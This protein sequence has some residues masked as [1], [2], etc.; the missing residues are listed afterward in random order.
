MKKSMATALAPG[1]HTCIN[2][3]QRI[4]GDDVNGH[5]TNT[6]SASDCQAECAEN[7]D[8]AKFTYYADTKACW[9]QDENAYIDPVAYEGADSG[10]AVCGDAT[11]TA[12]GLV[13]AAKTSNSTAKRTSPASSDDSSIDSSSG[14]LDSL[15][16]SSAGKSSPSSSLPNYAWYLIA[17]AALFLIA[18]GALAAKGGGRKNKSKRARKREEAAADAARAP[19]LAM[20]PDVAVS[21][22]YPL[23][24]ITT[25]QTVAAAPVNQAAPIVTHAPYVAAQSQHATAQPQI[26]A[27]PF[28]RMP[29]APVV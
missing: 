2:H 13:G 21:Y 29:T 5:F 1:A 18:M 12:V 6:L 11:G 4:I 7:V 16:S 20:G 22:Q 24:P 15:G 10:P 23:Q 25:I 3:N 28:T 17:F 26:L 19:V 14:N 8:C 9:R 27:Q